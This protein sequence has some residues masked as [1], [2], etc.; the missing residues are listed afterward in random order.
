MSCSSVRNE[1]HLT[2]SARRRIAVELPPEIHKSEVGPL[3]NGDVWHER[4]RHVLEGGNCKSVG[5]IGGVRVSPRIAVNFYIK[6]QQLRV[7]EHRDHFIVL[8]SMLELKWT[9]AGLRQRWTITG[10][11]IL[12]PPE[13]EGTTQEIRH[14]NR[15]ISWTREG[16]TCEP[17]PWHVDLVIQGLGVTL[18]V[19]TPL[20]KELFGRCRIGR[21]NVERRRNESCIGH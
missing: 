15:L 3:V 21:C 2:S 10:R 16:A 11:G 6:D 4:R 14:L 9:A 19:A 7:S 8:G 13:I 1:P 5:G 12:G 18:K 20:T 17:G